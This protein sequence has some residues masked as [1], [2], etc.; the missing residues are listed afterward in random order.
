VIVVGIDY[1]MSS[2]CVCVARDKIFENAH[3]H[4]LND[5]KS[6]IG[7]FKNIFGDAHD[8]YLLDQQRYENI[9]SW[10]LNIVSE[11]SPDETYVMIEDYSFGSKGKVFHIAENCGLLKYILYKNKYR[12][13]T[14]A[15]TVVKKYATG[16]GN[17]TKDLMYET[18]QNE[19]GI[20]L[21]KVLTPKCKLGSPVTDIVDAW[22]IAKYMIDSL[23]S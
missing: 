1:S 19:T 12:F 20:D 17:A 13:H 5:K 9:A 3:F 21:I 7:Q 16:K 22:Y 8:E 4:F 6:A 23:E 2:P 18:F 10:V 14:V 15:P 11:F